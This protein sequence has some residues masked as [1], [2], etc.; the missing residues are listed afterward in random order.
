MRRGVA[1]IQD[2]RFEA[3]YPNVYKNL[4]KPAGSQEGRRNYL[5]A[6]AQ[7][8]G[9]A[10]QTEQKEPKLAQPARTKQPSQICPEPAE[11][12][13]WGGTGRPGSSSPTAQGTQRERPRGLTAD[14][15]PQQ[16]FPLARHHL[17]APHAHSPS[18]LLGDA[19][20]LPPSSSTHS[21]TTP[22]KLRRSLRGRTTKPKMA[23]PRQRTG[24]SQSPPP[25]SLC[26]SDWTRLNL[27][28][29]IGQDFGSCP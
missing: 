9:K 11:V 10:S 27:E 15:V 17:R 23:A 1:G 2:S 13:A 24:D 28:P 5:W 8:R 6:T 21:V 14:P 22:P 12:T 19:G 16:R 29:P 3:R 26:V 18:P 25:P 20:V 7:I 4:R